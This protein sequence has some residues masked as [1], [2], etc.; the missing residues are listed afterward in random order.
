MDVVT[1]AF[2]YTGRYVARRLLG[3][4]VEVKT[5]TGHLERSN[6]FGEAVAVAP[7]DFDDPAALVR[8]LEGATTLYNTYWVR[9]TH[10]SA[11]FDRAVDNTIT[12]FH[13]ARQ[14]GVR[15]IVH[16]SITNASR[17]S[18]LPYFSGK[19]L[20]EDAL[21]HLGVPYAIVRP[22]V[23]FGREDIFINNM[24][25]ILRRFPI[26]AVPGSGD[27]RLQPVFVDD[28]AQLCVSS[29]GLQKNVIL[30]AVGPEIYRF[31]E[32]VRLMAETIGSK[33]RI[34]KVRP[35]VALLLSGVVGRAV[36]DVLITR[37]ELEGLMTDL[38]VSNGPP[39]CPTRLSQWLRDNATAVGTRYA[40]ELKRHYR[41][42]RGLG[43]EVAS[44]VSV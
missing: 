37:E 8:S 33:A 9:F 32:L 38:V 43:G 17:D 13:A 5:I 36:R 3:M 7:F 12:L 27:Y 4:G 19:A 23:I 1:G 44:E 42:A 39:T 10:G 2:G 20:V 6:P 21:A 15:R 29:G 35:G 28:V 14:A 25:W 26:F 22:T 18:P 34:V 30:D 16:V 31:A 41:P 11:S 24:A 40:S